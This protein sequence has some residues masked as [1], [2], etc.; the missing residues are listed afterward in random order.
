MF[1][2]NKDNSRQHESWVSE[3]FLIKK[4]PFMT[5][6]YSRTK[7][8]TNNETEEVSR[9]QIALEVQI[10]FQ[11]KSKNLSATFYYF[12]MKLILTLVK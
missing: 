5:V 10:N 3:Q 9:R 12:R 6:A 2:D 11:Q 7:V 1:K 8:I 4:N